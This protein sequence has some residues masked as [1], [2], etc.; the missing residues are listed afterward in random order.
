MEVPPR[1]R[2]PALLLPLDRTMMPDLSQ[3]RDQFEDLFSPEDDDFFQGSDENSDLLDC[4]ASVLNMS[5]CSEDSFIEL[6]EASDEAQRKSEEEKSQEIKAQRQKLAVQELL[7]SERNY[8]RMLQLSA[9]AIRENLLKI[10]PPLANLDSM[11]EQI[12][13]VISVTSRLLDSVDQDQ[14]QPGDPDLLQ[15]F[16]NAFLSLS[17]D[18]EAAYKEYLSD[19]SQVT[20]WEISSKQKEALWDQIVKVLKS[21]APELKASSLSFFLVTPVQRIARYPLLFQTIRKHTE[22]SHPAYE[23]LDRTALTSV[24]LNCRINEYKRIREFREVADKYK[25]TE[26]LSIKDMINRLNTH[27]IFKKTARLS[28]QIKHETG[29]TPKLVDEEFDALE[30]FFYLLEKCILELLENVETYLAHLHSFLSVKPEEF[31]LYMDAQR[32]PVCYKEITTAL[33]QWILPTFEK[34]LRALIHK[35]LCSLRDLLVGPRNL[36]RKRLDKLLDYELIEAKSILSY[37]EQAAANTYKTMNT[38][39]LTELPRFNTVSLQLIWRLL[40][41]FSCLHR[42]LSSD[43]TQLFQTF[44]TQLPHSAMS[45]S[46]FWEWAEA[47]VMEGMRKLQ[48]L[49]QTVEEALSAP[50]VMPVNPCWALRYR[51]LCQKHPRE[52]IFEAT[53]GAVGSRDLDL[54]LIKGELVAVVSERDSRGDRRRWLVDAG[55]K[56]GYAPASKLRQY[57]APP[58]EGPPPPSPLPAREDSRL[59]GRKLSKSLDLRPSHLAPGSPV[60]PLTPLAP[61][62]A[63]PLS[64]GPVFQ[65]VAA[66][67]FMARG[68]REVSLAAGEPVRILEPHDKKGNPE[69]SLVRT[70]AGQSGYVPSNYLTMTPRMSGVRPYP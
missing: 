31:D 20:A 33:R 34:R 12:P 69:W 32:E 19:Y 39:L 21:S 11:F 61:P 30:G 24:A 37:E 40:G 17:S 10:Q 55:G 6:K 41:T 29:I 2:P 67:A 27:S 16:C 60:T 25:K 48:D 1:P 22:P 56:R 26:T 68:P 43:M 35:P 36:I 38:L 13:D 47:A 59:E 7:E 64:P 70:G 46:A 65:V 44:A 45:P 63:P 52:R 42:D 15:T 5:I 18:I 49:C 23:L 3:D 28:Q 57:Q 62:P 9:G 53:A 51:Q 4:N 50:V 66:Y 14:L 54:S 58:A 8:L